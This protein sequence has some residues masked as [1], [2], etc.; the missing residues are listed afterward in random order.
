M[1]DDLVARLEH[2]LARTNNALDRLCD[3]LDR[4][5]QYHQ[6]WSRVIEVIEQFREELVATQRRTGEALAI[7]R[8]HSR[9]TRE[10]AEKM[11]ADVQAAIAA[12]NGPADRSRVVAAIERAK[13]AAGIKAVPE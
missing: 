6:S 9:A 3:A 11:T 7:G 1:N 10:A 13:Q 2:T 8:K 12:A 4:D 5:V